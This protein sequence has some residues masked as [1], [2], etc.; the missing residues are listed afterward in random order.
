MEEQENVP[1]L[2]PTLLKLSVSLHSKQL[3]HVDIPRIYGLAYLD[4]DRD[5][6][7]FYPIPLNI[8]IRAL[9]SVWLSLRV[10][11]RPLWVEKLR[12]EAYRKGFG[13]GWT[14][15]YKTGISSKEVK[16]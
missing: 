6:Y 4:P 13:D 1:V 9:K 10:G 12:S 14:D 15:G 3:G 2:K 16:L 11:I 5:F 8:L 7:V